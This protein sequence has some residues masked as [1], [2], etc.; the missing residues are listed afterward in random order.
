[1]V[2]KP[3]TIYQVSWP[4]LHLM[5]LHVHS[6]RK[7]KD[8]DTSAAIANEQ[9]PP[10]G[11]K[12]V[13]VLLELVQDSC[14]SSVTD[15]HLLPPHLFTLL[16]RRALSLTVS[17]SFLSFTLSFLS[18]FPFLPPSFFLSF[19]SSLLHCFSLSFLSLFPFLPPSFF[20][21]SPSSLLHCF[22]LSSLSFNSFPFF[23]LTLFLLLLT[24]SLQVP[25]SRG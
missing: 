15:C 24:L 16:S 14:S 2:F 17:L 19:P 13:T 12:V 3:V 20:H 5:F 18:L 9:G 22:S 10:R 23:L 1:M 21:S 11:W 8:K 25:S 6:L 7:V 4:V